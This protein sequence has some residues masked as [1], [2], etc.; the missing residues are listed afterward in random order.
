MPEPSG[1]I[2]LETALAT[3]RRTLASVAERAAQR[4]Y[5]SGARTDIINAHADMRAALDLLI[6][7]AA[8][9]EGSAA[10]KH[11]S[12]T[13][14]RPLARTIPDAGWPP[15]STL[16]VVN[17]PSEAELDALITG[18]PKALNG[19]PPTAGGQEGRQALS[20]Y[21]YY[22]FLALDRPLTGQQRAELRSM[23]TRGEITPA[24]FVN[25]YHWGDLEGDPHTMMGSC[26]DAFCI[27][28]TG[29]RGDRATGPAGTRRSAQRRRAA[30]PNVSWNCAHST[31]ASPAC[32][33]DSTRRAG[34]PDR[35]PESRA[36]GEAT[37]APAAG[38]RSPR[39]SQ[40]QARTPALRFPAPQPAPAQP[41]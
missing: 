14:G 12:G 16:A 1:G 18:P 32:W 31:S 40:P 26:F 30:S 3:A 36:R 19:S 21:Q 9:H 38:R 33:S 23:S 4:G 11:R 7:A 5:Y 41:P 24:R 8:G 17:E 6:M 39:S 35:R 10:A 25:E 28:R 22:E 15:R 27:W 34:P 13:A 37:L 29:G 20:E 2:A